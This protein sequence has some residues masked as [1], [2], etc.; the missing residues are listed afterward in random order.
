MTAFVKVAKSN[1]IELGQG[2][3]V[4]V[5]GKTIALSNVDGAFYAIDNTCTHRGGPLGEG[6]LNDNEVTCHWPAPC[7]T[8]P[9]ARC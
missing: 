2:K 1:E 6:L 9:R 7:L 4:E 8:L 3:M 5:D